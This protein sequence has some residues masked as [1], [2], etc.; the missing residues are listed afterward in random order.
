[1]LGTAALKASGIILSISQTL[2][3]LIFLTAPRGR[4]DYYYYITNREPEAQS[5]WVSLEITQLVKN[6]VS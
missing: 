3:H 4:Y 6:K 5:R 2:I 1:M